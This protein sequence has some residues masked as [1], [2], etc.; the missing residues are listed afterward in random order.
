MKPT[1]LATLPLALLLAAC[2]DKPAGNT[3]DVVPDSITVNGVVYKRVGASEAVT[4]PG[5]A[6]STVGTAPSAG[7]SPVPGAGGTGG[8]P[9]TLPTFTAP[10]GPPPSA[11]SAPPAGGIAPDTVS[12]SGSPPPGHGG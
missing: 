1:A 7:A 11:P 2:P 3:S 5:S 8:A 9:V 6:G 10:S 12:P 4:A